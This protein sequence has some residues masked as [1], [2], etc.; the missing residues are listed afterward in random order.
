MIRRPPRSTLFPYTT[1]FRSWCVGTTTDRTWGCLSWMAP[2]ARRPPARGHGGGRQGGCVA[3]GNRRTGRRAWPA[4]DA[5]LQNGLDEVGE[6][7]IFL[8]RAPPHRRQEAGLDP[9]GDRPLHA[10]DRKSTRLNS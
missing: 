7:P 9:Q 8:R 3:F 10:V 1:L 2:V 4:G 5:G 6:A